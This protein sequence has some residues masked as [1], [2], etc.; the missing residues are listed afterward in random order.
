MLEKAHRVAVVAEL[1]LGDAQPAQ[2]A[3]ASKQADK[4]QLGGREDARPASRTAGLARTAQPEACL[5][6]PACQGVTLWTFTDR[7][8]TTIETK[9]HLED[10]PLVFDDDYRPKPA[11]LA[12]REA[13]ARVTPRGSGAA[14]PSPAELAS[15]K[16]KP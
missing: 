16:E 6:V 5:A 9:T 4:R 13:L 12:V 14:I 11:A 2:R 1:K 3:R 10:I 8:P 7:Y 15:E